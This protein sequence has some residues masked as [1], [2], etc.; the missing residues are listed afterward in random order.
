[1]QK[2]NFGNYSQSQDKKLDKMEKHLG[3]I[4][5]ELGDTKV[6]MEK[7]RREMSEMKLD[8]VERIE[9]LGISI[10]VLK[11]SQRSKAYSILIPIMSAIITGLTV[12]LITH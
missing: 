2:S 9:K 6:E 11:V 5:E 8:I 12:F 10:A 4:N 7:I 3:V 1:M